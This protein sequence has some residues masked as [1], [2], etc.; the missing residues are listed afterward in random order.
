MVIRMRIK[1]AGL[2]GTIVM[3]VSF[4]MVSVPAEEE[5]GSVEIAKDPDLPEIDE[6]LA[7]DAIKTIEKQN[8]D[9]YLSEKHTTYICWSYPYNGKT[10]HL[11]IVL[12]PQDTTGKLHGVLSVDVDMGEHKVRNMKYIDWKKKW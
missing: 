3:I 4:L 9:R 2:I 11:D 5:K 10:L 12:N 1:I 6:S 7:E 8:F